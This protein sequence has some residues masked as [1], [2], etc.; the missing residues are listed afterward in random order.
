MLKAFA[1]R[2]VH[3]TLGHSSFAIFSKSIF[4]IIAQ[5]A[6]DTLFYAEFRTVFLFSVNFPVLG[7]FR[8]EILKKSKGGPFGEKKYEKNAIF[9]YIANTTIFIFCPE[10]TRDRFGGQNLAKN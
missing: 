9:C 8:F 5:G 2:Y 7:G 10:V 6:N 1:C 3:C 4:K